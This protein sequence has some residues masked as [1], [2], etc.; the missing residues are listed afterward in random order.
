METSKTRSCRIKS[1]PESN[2]RTRVQNSLVCARRIK[3]GI[4]LA[5]Y[6]VVLYSLGFKVLISIR[7][8]RGR[9][10]TFIFTPR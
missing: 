5:T 4:L 10:K 7:V 2:Y 8:Y 9:R 3:S 6:R 1:L